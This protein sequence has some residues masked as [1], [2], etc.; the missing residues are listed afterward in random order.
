MNEGSQKVPT[1]SY[2]IN[3]RDAMYTMINKIST[4]ICY[5]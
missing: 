2:E 3:I 5:I 4:I 1:F